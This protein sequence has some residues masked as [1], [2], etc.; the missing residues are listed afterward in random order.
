[1]AKPQQKCVQITL[2]FQSGL[3][4]VLKMEDLVFPD[5]QV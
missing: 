3:Q 5:S 1:M 4:V 2:F